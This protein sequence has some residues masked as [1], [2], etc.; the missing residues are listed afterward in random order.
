[1]FMMCTGWGPANSGFPAR[2]PLDEVK[3]DLVVLGIAGSPRRRGN[4]ETLLDRFLDGAQSAGAQVQKIVVA[5]LEIAGC[6]ACDRCWKDGHCVVEDQF[7]EVYHSLVSADVIVLAAPLFF[8][9]LPAQVKALV[10]RSQCQW[11]RKFKLKAPM[12]ATQAGHSRR[13]GV[14]V[15]VGGDSREHFSGALKTVQAFFDVQETDCW[16][17]LL[18]PGVDAKG[19]ILRHPSALQEALDLGV[20]A[21]QEDWTIR[22]R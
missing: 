2:G 8:W 7:Q 1:M 14:F 9:G 22:R 12:P 13:R 19:D 17:S 6:R 15:G 16:A 18:Y 5:R 20:R 11:A 3:E 10:D 4:T 21:I